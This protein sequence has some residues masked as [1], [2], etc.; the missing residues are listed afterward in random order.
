[1]PV[2]SFCAS[3]SRDATTRRMSA[4]ELVCAAP[5]QQRLRCSSVQQHCNLALNW[6]N[7]SRPSSRCCF[8]LRRRNLEEGRALRAACSISSV[9]QQHQLRR[10]SR[11]RRRQCPATRSGQ[12]GEKHHWAAP[13][14]YPPGFGTGRDKLGNCLLFELNFLKSLGHTPDK[15]RS[16][17]VDTF[18]GG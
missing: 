9:A 13:R 8:F 16:K 12:R 3:R 18:G 4:T 15:R 7:W 17:K 14:M 1:M 10:S 6:S 2:S 11:S 5:S